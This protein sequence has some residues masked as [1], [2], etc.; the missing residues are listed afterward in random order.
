MRR[1]LN[2][3]S[4]IG[5]SSIAGARRWRRPA[6]G[7]ERYDVSRSCRSHRTSFQT[8]RGSHRLRAWQGSTSVRLPP[9]L[10]KHANGNRMLTFRIDVERASVGS[11]AHDLDELLVVIARRDAVFERDAGRQARSD[12]ARVDRAAPFLGVV[13]RAC[14]ARQ[15]P[16]AVAERAEVRGE[17]VGDAALEPAQATG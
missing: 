2:P 11:R 6:I 8:T 7:G 13:M 10:A 5:P 12:L 14:A 15:D 17:G 3:Y 16:E 1:A 4:S 9:Q